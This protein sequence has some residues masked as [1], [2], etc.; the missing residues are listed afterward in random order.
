VRNRE[1]ERRESYVESAREG[2]RGQ[3]GKR[4]R[5]RERGRERERAQVETVF[6]QVWYFQV[7]TT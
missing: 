3:E 2:R 7:L 5:E 6:C 1:R 4:E